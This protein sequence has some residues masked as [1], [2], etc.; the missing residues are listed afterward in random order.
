[1][2]NEHRLDR[3]EERFA[4]LQRH[5]TEQDRVMLKLSEENARLR[6]E[7]EELRGRV[8][9]AALR[10]GAEGEPSSSAQE[11]PPHY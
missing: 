1:M 6:R 8:S 2:S 7:I 11:K 9:G 10:A 3:L 5:V 4:W